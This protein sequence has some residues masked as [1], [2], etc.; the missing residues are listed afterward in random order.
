MAMTTAVGRGPLD[1]D[2]DAQRQ[3]DADQQPAG[4][5]GLLQAEEGQRDRERQRDDQTDRPDVVLRD[6]VDDRLEDRQRRERD[7][8]RGQDLAADAWP[9]HRNDAQRRSGE[10]PR[11]RQQP[12]LAPARVREGLPEQEQGEEPED[13]A[14]TPNTTKRA[15]RW[16][17]AG[18][19]VS[20]IALTSS[21]W[22]GE[23][24]GRRARPA[25]DHLLTL[26]IPP[27]GRAG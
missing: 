19:A 26:S 4:Q 2:A 5:A 22:D 16:G 9:E 20:L 1:E 17:S 18:W 7:R 6:H 27:N 15:V 21:T 11:G 10:D 12:R 8:E 13:H 3:P 24:R 14:V 25:G 23:G